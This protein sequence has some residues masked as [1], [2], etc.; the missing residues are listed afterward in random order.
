M[1]PLTALSPLSHSV[2]LTRTLLSLLPP[3]VTG[4][5]TATGR[6]ETTAA[7]TDERAIEALIEQAFNDI[8]LNVFS[9]VQA[10]RQGQQWW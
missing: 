5:C 9:P 4:G 10:G 2:I 6:S 3:L 7:T 1:N 8:D